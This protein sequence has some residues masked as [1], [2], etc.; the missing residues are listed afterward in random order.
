M[1][2]LS[3][4]IDVLTYTSTQEST[5]GVSRDLEANTSDFLELHA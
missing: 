5:E 3:L 1:S 4:I 2:I